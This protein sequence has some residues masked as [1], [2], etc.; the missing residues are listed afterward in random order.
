[1][2]EC[3]ISKQSRSMTSQYKLSILLLE[4]GL[5]NVY[6]INYYN[7]ICG[8][9]V[10]QLIVPKLCISTFFLLFYFPWVGHNSNLQARLIS[11]KHYLSLPKQI[12]VNISQNF[13]NRYSS[14]FFSTILLPRSCLF[15][16]WIEWCVTP[17][18]FIKVRRLNDDSGVYPFSSI[19]FYSVCV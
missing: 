16:D 7:S 14:V 13:A 3:N 5:W 15:T 4:E 17:K 11:I 6:K 18:V 2:P 1:M 10:F 8:K 9:Q 19:M 12:A